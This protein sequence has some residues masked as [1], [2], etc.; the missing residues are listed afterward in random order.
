MCGAWADGLV[1]DATR[2]ATHHDLL[3]VVRAHPLLSCRWHTGQSRLKTI[4]VP[5]KRAVVT[6][7][8][9]SPCRSWFTDGFPTW[10]STPTTSIARYRSRST[11]L[12]SCWVSL[13]DEPPTTAISNADVKQG[14]TLSWSEPLPNHGTLHF[15]Q[16]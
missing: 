11:V 1:D 6:R 7:D 12:Q 14:R 15:V 16:S 9:R 13:L 10:H 3:Y 4:K 5:V 2:Q 8:N